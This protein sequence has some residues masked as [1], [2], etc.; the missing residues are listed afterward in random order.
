VSRWDHGDSSWRDGG[1]VESWPSRF[2]RAE[3]WPQP[4]PARWLPD[5]PGPGVT[6]CLRRPR[7]EDGRHSL[8]ILRWD[9]GDEALEADRQLLGPGPCGVDCQHEHYVV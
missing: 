3:H 2:E 5:R 6:A 8:E 7:A 4:R 1:S 9:S